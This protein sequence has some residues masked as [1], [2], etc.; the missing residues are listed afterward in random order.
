MRLACTAARNPNPI[1][2][3]IFEK[4]DKPFQNLS[5]IHISP[6]YL[7]DYSR[8]QLQHTK[9]SMCFSALVFGPFYFFYRKMC[10]R[11]M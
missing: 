11:D 1:S 9:I 8:M 3:R 2:T 7:N 5:L 4:A 6:V 10:I